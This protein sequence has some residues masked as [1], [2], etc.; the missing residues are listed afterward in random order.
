MK[1]LIFY[2]DVPSYTKGVACADY[3]RDEPDVLDYLNSFQHVGQLCAAI[4]DDGVNFYYKHKG[5]W[6]VVG[7]M[8][9][10]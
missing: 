2:L 1:R 9:G 3:S 10:L 7:D 5:N 8:P 6:E 4:F